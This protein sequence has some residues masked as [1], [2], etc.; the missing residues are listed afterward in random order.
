MTYAL[1]C[2]VSGLLSAAAS[3]SVVPYRVAFLDI[4][5][6]PGTLGSPI[7]WSGPGD[8]RAFS[9]GAG[10]LFPPP[11]DLIDTVPRLRWDDYFMFDPAGQSNGGDS[12]VA[13]D[14][15]TATGPSFLI[16]SA[17][18]PGRA[19]GLTYILGPDGFPGAYGGSNGRCFLLN[20]TLRTGSSAPTTEGV[21][22]NI[23]RENDAQ[24]ANFA[25]TAL[26][27]G[28]ENATNQ[29]VDGNDAATPYTTQRF[30]YLDWIA[31]DVPASELPPSFGP[32]INYQ[33]FVQQTDVPAPS[34]VVAL[35]SAA[36]WA[37][38]R[39]RALQER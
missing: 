16:G 1:I 32:G 14:G 18:D 26:R 37:N 5:G 7:T 23:L 29:A 30:Y 39:R 4:G 17:F 22:I 28:I 11:A 33:I 25:F 34:T 20:L 27:F 13:G 8:N 6:A 2:A 31:T 9:A 15:Y 38:R 35:I 3:A 10:S 21:Y 24:S 19:L 12:A 36:G